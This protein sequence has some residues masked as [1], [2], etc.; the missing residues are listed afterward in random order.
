M[1]TLPRLLGLFTEAVFILLGVL[2]AWLAWSGRVVFDRHSISWIILGA[3]LILWGLRALQNA[4]QWSM[5]W[6]NLV[7]GASL[8]LVGVAMLGAVQAP[9]PWVGPMIAAAGLSLVLRGLLGALFIL[10]SR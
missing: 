9:F 3:A 7:R 1:L 8:V 10:R 4:G 5:R 6:Q 2:I